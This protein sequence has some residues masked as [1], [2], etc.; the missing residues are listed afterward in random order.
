MDFDVSI[1]VIFQPYKSFEPPSSTPGEDR[2]MPLQTFLDKI[3]GQTTF[4]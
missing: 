2:H 4:I 1:N 3:Q